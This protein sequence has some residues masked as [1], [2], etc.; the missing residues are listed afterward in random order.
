VTTN[1]GLARRAEGEPLPEA[2]HRAQ[3]R[4]LADAGSSRDLD[5]HAAAEKIAILAWLAF[6]ID[7]A[8]VPVQRRDLTPH[9]DA[10]RAAARAHG[11]VLRQVAECTRT[12]GGVSAA[13]EP[14]IVP[15]TSPLA[16]AAGEENCVCIETRRSG[17]IR[18]FGPG[19][20]G[21]PAAAALLGDLLSPAAPEPPLRPSPP[22]PQA[23]DR[24]H[25]W[26][27]T[28]GGENLGAA[29]PAFASHGLQVHWARTEATAL[30]ARIGPAPRGRVS[31]CLAA[32]GAAGVRLVA[33]RTEVP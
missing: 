19:T 13:V 16:Q 3:L 6:G 12:E 9:G 28:G 23:E 8:T 21:Q 20:G 7:P 4:G 18:L 31:A 25:T 24:E 15:A 26:A 17:T 27:V 1:Y 22:P 11:G 30:H 33:V 10:L 2:L 29:L 14:V 32:L 5:G